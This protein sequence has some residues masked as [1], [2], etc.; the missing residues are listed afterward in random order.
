MVCGASDS[1][2]NGR[3]TLTVKSE[4]ADTNAVLFCASTISLTQCVCAWVWA[5][6]LV[7]VWVFEDVSDGGSSGDSNGFSESVEFCR[8][9]FR[10]HAHIAPSL[11]P[12]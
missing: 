8:F 12:E 1:F 4:D 3:H 11:P 10:F 6:N 2:D 7:E 5:R 9:K